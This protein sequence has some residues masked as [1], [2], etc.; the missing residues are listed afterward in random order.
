MF[1]R[2][3]YTCLLLSNYFNLFVPRNFTAILKRATFLD[4]LKALF[5]RLTYEASDNHQKVKLRKNSNWKQHSSFHDNSFASGYTC[6][7]TS[8]SLSD[9]S[10]SDE[11]QAKKLSVC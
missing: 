11:C 4:L 1:V 7:F 5:L 9:V 3:K 8:Q 2:G 6:S 10:F